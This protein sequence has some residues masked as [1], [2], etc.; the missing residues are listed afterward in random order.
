MRASVSIRTMPGGARTF[1]AGVAAGVRVVCG[2]C[3]CGKSVRNAAFPPSAFR[4]LT[5]WLC[6]RSV[7]E[8]PAAVLSLPAWD[9]S[10]LW[11]ED[12]SAGAA[13]PG[14][15]L[16][17]PA[18]SSSGGGGGAAAGHRR[19]L[20]PGTEL[21]AFF[22]GD[23][24]L[25][26][27]ASPGG[28]VAPGGINRQA[29]EGLERT[30]SIRTKVRLRRVCSPS[31]YVCRVGWLCARARGCGPA[32]R[33]VCL[34]VISCTT[35]RLCLS[36]RLISEQPCGDLHAVN[37]IVQAL[38][39][40]LST[41]KSYGKV[42]DNI[43]TVYYEPLVAVLSAAEVRTIF[44][45]AAVNA[46]RGGGICS[47]TI[48]PPPTPL[49]PPAPPPKPGSAPVAENLTGAAALLR[50][51]CF[52]ALPEIRDCQHQVSPTTAASCFRHSRATG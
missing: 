50:R 48:P 34:P 24:R 26:D 14:A 20:T 17:A 42:L 43:F 37:L 47:S 13:S 18:A 1:A 25:P 21:D 16:S 46:D 8:L 27:L 29:S 35:L 33:Y 19:T 51:W 10:G 30:L 22:S 11:V 28:G 7:W 3:V 15:R 6:N 9:D 52:A 32:S 12:Y 45:G 38:K 49:R 5:A 40:L 39:E 2:V 36:D 44:T 41:E 4:S 23:G 31:C